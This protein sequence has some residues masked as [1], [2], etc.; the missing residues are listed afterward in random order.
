MR[1]HDVG[2]ELAREE[3]LHARRDRAV[4]QRLPRVVLGRAAGA[5]HTNASWPC[6][7]AVRVQMR[8]EGAVEAEVEP[9]RAVMWN[10]GGCVGVLDQCGANVAAGLD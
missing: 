10:W 8:G 7:A 3:Q 6:S 1:A 2:R 9:V 4:D 5:Q